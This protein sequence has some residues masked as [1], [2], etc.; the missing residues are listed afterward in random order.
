MRR[1]ATGL[2][3]SS[4]RA[5]LAAAAILTGGA[6]DDARKQECDKF[7]GAM[8]PLDQ[9]TPTAEQV[10]GAAT[11]I[12]AITFQNEP[13]QIYAKNYLEKLTVL[14]STLKLK[15]GSSAPDGTDDVIK[16]YLKDARTDRDDVQRFCS[17]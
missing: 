13:L 10:D 1:T 9:G 8:K 5:V 12:K 7:L 3:A 16:K 11:Q 6:C 2:F 15:A 4:F 14:S 17:K